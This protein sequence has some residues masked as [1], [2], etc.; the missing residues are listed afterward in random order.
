MREAGPDK[1]F[2]CLTVRQVI[3]LREEVGPG[4]PFDCH[5]QLQPWHLQ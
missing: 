1:P 3:N 4:K 5:P 2:D